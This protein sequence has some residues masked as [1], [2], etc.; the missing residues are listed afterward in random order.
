VAVVV[1]VALLASAVFDLMNLEVKGRKRGHTGGI[2]MVMSTIHS[3][4]SPHRKRLPTPSINP[5]MSSDR[6]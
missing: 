3:S 1:V 4:I 2:D 5:L 6:R